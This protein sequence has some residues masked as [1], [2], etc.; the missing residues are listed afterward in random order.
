MKTNN[1]NLQTVLYLSAAA[2]LVAGL[3]GSL[4]IYLTAENNPGG[5]Q[6]Y[7]IVGGYVYSSGSANTKKYTHD[8]ELYGG[9]AA[10]L[11]EQ[12]SRWFR[13]LWHGR[14]LAFTVAC[15]A[16]LLSS[17]IFLAARYLSH[18]MS[19]TGGRNNRDEVDTHD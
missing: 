17:G 5:D 10:V 13:G 9:K 1:I 15:V 16:M 3:A 2:I 14:S 6:G 12:F 7:E 19:G 8:L 4:F 18:R 11:A